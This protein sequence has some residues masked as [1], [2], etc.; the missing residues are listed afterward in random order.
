M[1]SQPKARRPASHKPVLKA[2]P[3]PRGNLDPLGPESVPGTPPGR[4]L[5]DRLTDANW[6]TAQRRALAIQIGQAQGNRSLQRVLASAA[7]PPRGGGNTA[8]E[9]V[10]LRNP[11]KTATGGKPAVRKRRRAAAQSREG[12]PD[13]QGDFT[14]ANA[15]LT[16]FNT[17]Q[18]E[19][20]N[21]V[22]K[23]V[24]GAVQKFG[25]YTGIA[26]N[27]A[28][29]FPLE[30]VKTVLKL[31]PGADP[32]V[33]GLEMAEKG[34]ALG[35]EAGVEFTAP[36]K[37]PN[38]QKETAQAVDQALVSHAAL[39]Q[40]VTEQLKIR[41]ELLNMLYDSPSLRSALGLPDSLE[42]TV[43]K[44]LGP[45]PRYDSQVVVTL[46]LEYELRLYKDYYV[47]H[48]WIAHIPPDFVSVPVT[49]YKIHSVPAAVQTRLVELYKLLGRTAPVSIDTR[50][51]DG[52]YTR[53]PSDPK[54]VKILLDLGVKLY[55][56]YQRD[57]L[58]DSPETLHTGDDLRQPYKGDRHKEVN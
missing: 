38:T 47:R 14:K 52:H 39:K 28:G 49:Q 55:N 30:I 12:Q 22:Y 16:D 3:G 20:V 4:N 21:D 44:M 40:A 43:K 45:L 5:A 27:Q 17:L 1:E 31:I 58:F 11:V 26:D 56:P 35:K 24:A 19:I 37:T 57:K 10:I 29:E 34:L 50:Y 53:N 32:V 48:A 51:Y 18:L 36:E 54:A 23:N 15:Y 7:R 13:S 9:R 8:S 46:G 2:E 33:R 41:R 25:Y 42:Q 6:A